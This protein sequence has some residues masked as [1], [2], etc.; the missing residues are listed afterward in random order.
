MIRTRSAATLWQ[1]AS[2]SWSAWA[3]RAHVHFDAGS[4][5]L[6]AAVSNESVPE[7]G[8]N[9]NVRIRGERIHLF[10]ADGRSHH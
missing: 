9:I 1:G 6:M 4:H 2:C 8:E 10:G 7:V 5:R 3:E